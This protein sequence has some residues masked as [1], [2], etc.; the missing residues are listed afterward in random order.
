MNDQYCEQ[1]G[2]DRQELLAENR[3]LEEENAR[4]EKQKDYWRD[5]A[6]E[7]CTEIA[8]LRAKL[9]EKDN[10]IGRMRE[11]YI[12]TC[13]AKPDMSDSSYWKGWSDACGF[14]GQALQENS[15]E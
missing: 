13:N 5:K 8:R 3:A 9:A 15:D 14:F 11:A 2:C 7:L 4:L 1:R 10:E 6:K 12:A